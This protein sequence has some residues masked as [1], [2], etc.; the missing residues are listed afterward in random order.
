MK[1]RNL[2][3]GVFCCL[4]GLTWF[5][6]FGIMRLQKPKSPISPL[7]VVETEVTRT[8]GEPVVEEQPLIQ[9]KNERG[10]PHPNPLI[11]LLRRSKD[12]SAG[13][14][15]VAQSLV[16]NEEITKKQKN[17]KKKKKKKKRPHC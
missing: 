9:E 13:E 5:L 2:I 10:P 8:T 3:F 4:V 1:S 16:L 11:E 7:L 14:E 15:G 17:K 6:S 12:D